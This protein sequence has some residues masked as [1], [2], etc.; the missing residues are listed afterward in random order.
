[1][2]PRLLGA[3]LLP[4]ALLL[5][6]ALAEPKIALV[7][8]RDIYLKQ[9]SVKEARDKAVK[10]KQSLLT[11]PRTK[12]LQDSMSALRNIQLQISNT[13]KT[14][15]GKE[16]RELIREFQIK[17]METQILQE[18]FEKFAAERE[19]QINTEMVV[20]I[21]ALLNRISALSQRIA[22][23]KG[24]DIVLDSSGESNSSVPFVLYAKDAPDLTDDVLAALEDETSAIQESPTGAEQTKQ[25]DAPPINADER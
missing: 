24:Y 15:G 1:M 25:D 18:D 20:E 11:Y 13:E 10:N 2:S 7:R 5:T 3:M 4:T 23:E 8:V 16:L 19:K 9:P 14:P 21:R 12:D 6:S 22:R 17:R